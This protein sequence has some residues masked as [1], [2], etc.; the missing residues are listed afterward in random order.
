MRARTYQ[1]HA[2]GYADNCPG[3]VK[4]HPYVQLIRTPQTLP[5]QVPRLAANWECKQSE[6]RSLVRE[7]YLGLLLRP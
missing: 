2:V 1:R 5:F 3:M 4:F 6:N 7:M